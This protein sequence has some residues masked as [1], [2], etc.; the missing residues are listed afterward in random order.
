MFEINGYLSTNKPGLAEYRHWSSKTFEKLLRIIHIISLFTAGLTNENQDILWVSDEDDII[1]NQDLI[2]EVVDIFARISS[3]YL[4]H[5]LRHCRVGT[6]KSDVDR[7]LEDLIAVADL[8]AG[9]LS[10]YFTVL[11]QEKVEYQYCWVNL[12]LEKQHLCGK[13]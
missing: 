9:A 6:T 2:Y 7:Q 1:P 4:N 12:E 5:D 10:D 8:T 13:S 3:H 11:Y